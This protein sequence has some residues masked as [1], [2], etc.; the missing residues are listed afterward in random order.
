MHQLHL[1]DSA[2]ETT[3]YC[4]LWHT[5]HQLHLCDSA[6]ET[7]LEI[8]ISSAFRCRFC[9]WPPVKM[10]HGREFKS[11]S[12]FTEILTPKN[13]T[14]TPISHSL[15]A[16]CLFL[17]RIPVLAP[18]PHTCAY[19]P[20]F[21]FATN[22]DYHPCAFT[23]KLPIPHSLPAA[24]PRHLDFH[25]F[26]LLPFSSKTSL[27]DPCF[28]INFFLPPHLLSLPSS[29]SFSPRHTPPP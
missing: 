16:Q 28:N 26:T 7:T 17:N 12:R 5:V 19:S 4:Q 21:F 25:S 23:S 24:S 11:S 10:E 14:P 3:I 18:K 20:L 27:L 2:L 29:P 22:T 6:P 1:C 13:P 8:C 9:R 15:C